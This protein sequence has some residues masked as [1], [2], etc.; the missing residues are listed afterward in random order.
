MNNYFIGIDF[1]KAKFDAVILQRDNL[2]EEGHHGTFENSKTGYKRFL[3][4]V[5]TFATKHKDEV[6]FCGEHTGVYSKL[7]SDLLAK[8]DYCIWLESPLQIKRSLGIKRG[9]SDKQDAHDIAEFAARHEDKVRVHKA[10]S[11][12]MEALG[13]YFSEYKSWVEAKCKLQCCIKAHRISGAENPF[14]KR[15]IKTDQHELHRIQE[16]IK[17]IKRSIEELIKQ[18]PE[19]KRTYQILTSMKGIGIINAVALILATNNFAR[20]DHD[21]RRLCSYYGVAP[22]GHTS[23]TSINGKPHVSHFADSYLKSLISEAALCAMHHCPAIIEYA[24][25]LKQKGKHPSIIMNNCKNKML[26]ILVAMVK[27]NTEYGL[28]TLFA[29]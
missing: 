3:G 10:P 1:A 5:R 27:H 20:F 29:A 25:R 16:R 19:I 26:H 21:A 18:C 17:A 24:E 11:K 13:L 14:F 15:E 2:N 28:Q 12:E 9:K 22:F 7:I 23:G 8:D 4:W 6:L